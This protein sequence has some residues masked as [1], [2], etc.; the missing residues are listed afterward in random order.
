MTDL[1]DQIDAL[2]DAPTHDVGRI[3]H[4][5]TDGYAEAL[6]LE[7]E[8]FRLERRIAEVAAGIELGDVVVSA[9]ELS[10]L[11]TRLDGSKDDLRELRARLGELRRL[12]ADA[13]LLAR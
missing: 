12:A 3:E 7:A 6:L 8:Q 13:R 2:I 9:R 11:A 10:T 4:T 1:L 5:L